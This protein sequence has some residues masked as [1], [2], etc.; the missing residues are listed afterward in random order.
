[1][2][3]KVKNQK[4]KAVVWGYWQRMNNAKPSEVKGIFEKAF[5][6]NVNWNGSQPF[7]QIRGMYAII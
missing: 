3:W 6:E 5:D 7:N 1:M 2:D 4:N